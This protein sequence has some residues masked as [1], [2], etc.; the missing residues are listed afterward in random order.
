MSLPDSALFQV[1][2]QQFQCSSL[3]NVKNVLVGKFIA[4]VTPYL[5]FLSANSKL[6]A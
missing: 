4:V 1:I 2:V 6:S 3:A 5:V